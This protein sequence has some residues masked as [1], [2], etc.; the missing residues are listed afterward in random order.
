[1]GLFVLPWNVFLCFIGLLINFIHHNWPDLLSNVNANF[2]E[3]F[4]TPIVKVTKGQEQLSFF[5]IPEYEEWKQQT[6]NWH[7]WTIKYYKG[8]VGLLNV[9]VRLLNKNLKFGID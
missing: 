7:R 1:M 2:V 4:I 9:I 5:S 6:P 8:N 3:E